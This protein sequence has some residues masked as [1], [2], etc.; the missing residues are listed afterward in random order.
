MVKQAAQIAP[1]M[2]LK[3]NAAVRRSRWSPAAHPLQSKGFTLATPCHGR[4]VRQCPVPRF[5]GP[6]G[7][8]DQLPDES[9]ILRFRHVLEKHK[10]AERILS[11]RQFAAGCR[12]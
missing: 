11:N 10:L 9:T 1:F 12:A 8:D 5:A 4:G 2:P 6:G 7:W 3:V